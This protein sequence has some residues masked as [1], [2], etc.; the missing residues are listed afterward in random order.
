[1]RVMTVKPDAAM[2]YAY[3]L[4]KARECTSPREKQKILRKA[5]RIRDRLTGYEI[6]QARKLLCFRT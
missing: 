5:L 6:Q 2:V 3:L 1:M 4:R